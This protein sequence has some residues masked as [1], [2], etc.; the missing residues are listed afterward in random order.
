[1][2]GAASGLSEEDKKLLLNK[3]QLFNELKTDNV[4]QL[5]KLYNDYISSIKDL[6]LKDKT[7]RACRA[8]I[9]H[10]INIKNYDKNEIVKLQKELGTD[11]ISF[12]SSKLKKEIFDFQKKIFENI[13]DILKT[14]NELDGNTSTREGQVSYH[15]NKYTKEAEAL[16][17]EDKMPQTEIKAKIEEEKTRYVTEESPEAKAKAKKDTAKTQK[18]KEKAVKERLAQAEKTQKYTE[19]ED[20]KKREREKKEK[21]KKEAQTAKEA[22]EH[23]LH[24]LALTRRQEALKVREQELLNYKAEKEIERRM[25][26]VDL[27]LNREELQTKTAQLLLKKA[28]TNPAILN[29]LTK[30]NLG[31]R[32]SQ[33]STKRASINSSNSNVI[34]GLK[35]EI[36][37]HKQVIY[38]II[39]STNFMTHISEFNKKYS[40]YEYKDRLNSGV[41]NQLNEIYLYITKLNTAD[42]VDC[43]ELKTLYTI[44]D[45]ELTVQQTKSKKF[46]KILQTL[47]PSTTNRLHKEMEQINAYCNLI[48][49]NEKL[50]KDQSQSNL[51]QN[52]P[53][54]PEPAP[55]TESILVR[56]CKLITKEVPSTT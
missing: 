31:R 30:K 48:E 6:Q 42:N 39:K 35:L 11:S 2:S 46:K 9:K 17:P 5:D 38:D 10:L 12:L 28:E 13:S 27:E 22:E 20:K 23:R 56:I 44:L 55:E 19:K 37:E 45:S 1:M 29:K 32:G 47:K 15:I 34:S 8:I 51:N 53:P 7:S 24:T 14:T 43:K 41:L 25:R 3:L 33:N 50:I 4:N 40:E 36:K 54:A 18:D 21:E 26:E 16:K 49:K 52:Q